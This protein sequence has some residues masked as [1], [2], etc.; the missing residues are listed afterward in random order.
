MTVNKYNK[1]CES[2]DSLRSVII[3]ALLRAVKDGADIL[4]LS[5]GGPDGWTESAGSV[6]ASRIAATGKIVTIAASNE[7]CIALSAWQF[8]SRLI[9][10]CRV[11]L[12]PGLLPTPEMAS[13]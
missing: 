8:P 13:T 5:L 3:D 4:N 9:F 10:F 12:V 1:C 2:H 6:V 7:V 11:L